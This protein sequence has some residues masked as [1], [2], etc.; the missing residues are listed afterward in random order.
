MTPNFLTRDAAA[1]APT[2]AGYPISAATLATRASRG[3]W[4]GIS[5]VLWP[6]ALSVVRSAVMGRKPNQRAQEQHFRR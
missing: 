3:G 4:P 1:N 6:R 2:A 5:D